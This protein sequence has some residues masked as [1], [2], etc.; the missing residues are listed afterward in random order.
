MNPIFFPKLSRIEIIKG[1]NITAKSTIGSKS[2]KN[3][4]NSIKTLK[5]F[6]EMLNNAESIGPVI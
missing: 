4:T 3:Y 5:K 1:T 2:L 6:T